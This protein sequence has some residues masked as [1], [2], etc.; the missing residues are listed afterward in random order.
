MNSKQV[1]KYQAT[2]L[3]VTLDDKKKKKI[4]LVIAFSPAARRHPKSIWFS[5]PPHL[6]PGPSAMPL[7]WVTEASSSLIFV[8]PLLFQQNLFHSSQQPDESLRLA[9]QILIPV[10]N[11]S[12][13]FPWHL[14]RAPPPAQPVNLEYLL[15][16]LKNATPR[17]PCVLMPQ[18]HWL[19]YYPGNLLGLSCPRA[20]S[21]AG[22]SAWN[23]L[24]SSHGWLLLVI[25]SRAQMSLLN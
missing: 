9:N 21:F 18:L 17:I 24:H 22:S 14:A 11:P 4:K 23:N 13:F 16:F 15:R 8:F 10:P 2:Y 12:M 19:F 1:I 5:P 7:C 3:G 6:S 20:F 25:W